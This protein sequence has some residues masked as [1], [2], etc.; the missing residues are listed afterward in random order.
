[1]HGYDV[2]DPYRWLEASNSAEMMRWLAAQQAIFADHRARWWMLGE[3]RS[4]IAVALTD[5]V[6]SPPKVRGDRVFATHRRANDE[7]PR[8]VVIHQDGVVRVLLDLLAVDIEGTT[9][10][11]RWDPSP[12]GHVI[13]V[14]TSRRGTEHGASR[15]STRPAAK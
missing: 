2:A 7:H 9:T 4:R 6:W 14:Q 10:L 5:D 13:A 1:M 11:D 12:C 3:M 8:L 15:S